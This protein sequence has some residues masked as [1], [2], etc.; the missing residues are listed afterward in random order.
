MPYTYTFTDKQSYLLC[1]TGGEV[2]DVTALIG[3]SE[4]IIVETQKRDRSRLLIDDRALTVDLLPLEVAIFGDHL[5]NVDFT[6]LGLRIAVVYSPINTA[7]SRFFETALT[8]RSVSFRTFKYL[9]AAEEW[10]I[11]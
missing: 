6:M 9:K 5:Q 4:T 11:S 7:I 2:K 3:Y 8:N 10:L 1:V